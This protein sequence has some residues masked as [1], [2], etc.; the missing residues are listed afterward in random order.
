ML[1]ALGAGLDDLPDEPP[2]WME[3]PTDTE[4]AL[5]P[6]SVYQELAALSHDNPAEDETDAKTPASEGL[7][8]D[9]TVLDEAHAQQ[10]DEP[11]MEVD[12]DEVVEEAVTAI[13]EPHIEILEPTDLHE[14]P[15]IEI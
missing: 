3:T 14:E 1:D 2:A 4:T 13:E 6:P 12:L 11:G 10:T 8:T 9:A 5:S 7:E 15:D